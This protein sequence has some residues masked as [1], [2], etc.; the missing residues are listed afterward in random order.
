MKLANDRFCCNVNNLNDL[1]LG[2]AD[3][4]LAFVHQ[5]KLPNSVFVEELLWKIFE[6]ARLDVN[7]GYLTL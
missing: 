4:L 1:V 5:Q 2:A 3:Q 6:F 7:L